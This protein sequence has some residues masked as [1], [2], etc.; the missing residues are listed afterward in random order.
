MRANCM[1]KLSRRCGDGHYGRATGSGDAILGLYAVKRFSKLRMAAATLLAAGLTWTLT[2]AQGQANENSPETGQAQTVLR[3]TSNL[4]LVRVEARDDRGNPVEGLKKDNFKVFDRG[5][6]QTVT[7][8]EE[9]SAVS[10]IDVSGQVSPPPSSSGAMA[11]NFLALYFDDQHASA[12]DLLRSREAVDKYLANHLQPQDR[13]AI[14]TSGAVLSDFTS[15]LKQIHEALLKLRV[16]PSAAQQISDCLQLSDREAAEIIRTPFYDANNDAW[17]EAMYDALKCYPASPSKLL[18]D[19]VRA[20][21][22]RTVQ[23]ARTLE[24]SSVDGLKLAV[25]AASQMPGRRKVIMVSPGFLPES[26]E[27]ELNRIIDQA[28][29]W[30][31][32]VSSLDP[33]GLVIGMREADA[34]KSDFGTGAVGGA[35]SRVDQSREMAAS[36]VLADLTYGTGGEF[37]HNNNGLDEGFG[38]LFGVPAYYTLGFTPTD[39]KQDG[40]FHVLRITLVGDHKGVNL[41]ARRGYFATAESAVAKSKENRTSGAPAGSPGPTTVGAA[42][43]DPATH[44]QLREALFAQTDTS[45]LAVKLEIT[46]GDVKGEMH[47]LSAA[48]HLDGK[49]LSFRKD[50][51]NSLNTV[52]FLFAVFDLKG[53]LLEHQQKHVDLVVSNGQMPSFLSVGVNEDAVFQLKPG[54]YRLREIVV[55][56]VEHHMT[57]FS[58][59]VKVQ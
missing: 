37:F 9:D 31:V 12:G 42:A 39:L 1:G 23:E 59:S 52:T 20:E 49:D 55:D 6:E 46:L 19:Q 2:A 18:E 40:K 51:E 13:V 47:E 41:Q 34:S 28:L 32:V 56:A 35:V 48:A 16:S 25:T 44:E 8:F 21:A 54:A 38:I 43:A 15:N 45:Q 53:N 17:K 4:V 30:Q 58:R 3:T 24:R 10:A 11:E 50:G 33:R 26:E 29:R 14:F 5:K 27:L 57:S 36:G 7:Q 22:Q